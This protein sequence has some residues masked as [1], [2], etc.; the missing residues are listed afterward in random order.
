MVTRVLDEEKVAEDDRLSECEVAVAAGGQRSRPEYDLR[1]T[2]P[3]GGRQLSWESHGR[4]PDGLEYRGSYGR[5][6]EFRERDEHTRFTQVRPLSLGGKDLLLLDW[7]N[8]TRVTR[9]LDESTGD[10]LLAR[11]LGD[12]R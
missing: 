5:H 4:C 1:W 11:S 12:S 3:H 9:V 2:L 10:L 8:L 7:I 6:G